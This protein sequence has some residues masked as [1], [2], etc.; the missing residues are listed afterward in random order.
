MKQDASTFLALLTIYSKE[1]TPEGLDPT[2][3]LRQLSDCVLKPPT[4]ASKPSQK[5]TKVAITQNH[6]KEVKHVF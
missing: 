6:I 5:R 3:E 4:V 1:L 2:S